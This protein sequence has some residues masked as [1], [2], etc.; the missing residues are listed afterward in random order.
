LGSAVAALFFALHPLRAES[1]A[2]AT[3]RRDVL[4]SLFFL[5]TILMYLKAA[6]HEGLERRRFQVGSVACFLLALLSKSIVMT[7]PFVLVLLDIYPL[8]RLEVRWKMWQDASARRVLKE[9]LP[10]LAI[11]LAGAIT[12]YW[13]VASHHY[14]TDM[15]KFGW[16]GRFAIAG[17]SLWFYF[18]KTFLPISLSPLYELPAVIDPLEPRFLL[19]GVAVVGVT[20]VL[21][22][23]HRW[24]P[25]GLAAWIYYG[26]ILGPVSGVA[27]SGYQLAHDRYSYLSCLGWALLVGAAAGTLARAAA[28]GA[29]RPLLIRG[30]A[31]VAALWI[32]GL[33]TLSWYQI[34]V[35]RD[36]ETLWR[37]AVESDPS[38]S[39]CQ[40]N[41]GTS[42]QHRHLPALAKDR[43]DLALRLRPDLARVHGILGP[44]LQS[45]GHPETALYHLEIALAKYPD[46]PPVLTN[47]AA[48]LLGQ[49]RYSDALA[50]LEHAH[51]IDSDFV[52]A[53]VNLGA[54]LGKTGRPAE[55]VSYLL[56]ARELR[57]DEPIVHLN[58][59]RA[60]RDLGKSELAQAEYDVL[61]K[62]DA[63]L[64]R[65][66]ESELSPDR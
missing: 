15:T 9:K 58:L 22:T 7:L 56:R 46:D 2:W 16:P 26:L 19:S 38:C 44:L 54:V 31:A 40:S 13:A 33:A 62:L 4:A 24:W 35:W 30:A 65:S 8:R 60:Y 42:L 17:Y 37:F 28:T 53:L 55:A 57:P 10:Y 14:L 59:L 11:G 12:S 61:R 32:V 49:E 18:E 3:E 36:T 34:Q 66:L 27:H 64:A 51:R 50:Y 25:A 20:A 1:V 52:P 47:M 21:L 29:V 5:L 45:M 23:V 39:V 63:P 43:Y 48:V 6:E 41:L